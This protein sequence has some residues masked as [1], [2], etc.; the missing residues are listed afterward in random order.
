MNTSV[1]AKKIG[2]SPKT[3]QRWIKQLELPM[4]RNEL[5]HYMFGNEDVSLLEDIH[6][7]LQ[8]GIPMN[9]IQEKVRKKKTAKRGSDH[10]SNEW[11]E[12][13]FEKI[14]EL[15]HLINKKADDVVSYQ[16][17]LQRNEIEEL[18][19]RLGQL[20]KRIA[21]LEKRENHHDAQPL[22]VHQPRKKKPI[23]KTWFSSIF[24]L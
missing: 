7:Q 6:S 5:G 8:K 17:L 2:V 4:E 19:S 24:G 12:K 14:T 18:T 10:V 20:E 21:E 15:E 16:L 13:A 3:I 9:E 23:H 11:M 1:V 22:I